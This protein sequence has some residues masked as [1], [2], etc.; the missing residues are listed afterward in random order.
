MSHNEDTALAASSESW[1]GSVEKEAR[2][3]EGPIDRAAPLSMI[4]AV[5]LIARGDR[6]V[7]GST[8]SSP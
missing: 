7:P 8:L 6:V 5:G 3:P 4:G 1:P 2:R